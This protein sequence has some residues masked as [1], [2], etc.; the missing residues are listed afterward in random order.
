[1]NGIPVSNEITKRIG[2]DIGTIGGLIL[3][4]SCMGGALAYLGNEGRGMVNFEAFIDPP[5]IMMVVGGVLAV[6]LVGFPMSRVLSLFPIVKMLFVRKNEHPAGVIRE[7]VALA[8]V[9]RREGLLALETR[10]MDIGD[11][12]LR[13]GIQL[14]VDG[15]KPETVEEVM[16]TEM[17]SM[18]TRHHEG[19]KVLETVGRCGPAFGMIATLL[20]LVMMLGNLSNAASIGPSMAVALIGTLYGALIANLVCIPMAEKLGCLNHEE[21]LYKEIVLRGIL[22]IQAG[23][24]PRIV[25]QKVITFL[26]PK[27]R[28]GLEDYG[29]M[30][31]EAGLLNDQG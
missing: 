20:G 19:R 25:L 9:A 8:E 7:V 3:A 2:L 16:R 18:Q 14:S 28:V 26:P 23:D 27:Y 13:L 10:T 29:M 17:E 21:M 22:A 24:N 6:A 1:M 15:I 30:K 5:A 12:F 31:A 4:I 11:R